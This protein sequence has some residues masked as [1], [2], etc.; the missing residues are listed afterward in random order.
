MRR[1]A[2]LLTTV[3][4]T[5]VGLASAAVADQTYSGASGQ[6]ITVSSL[7]GLP[8]ASTVHVTGTGFDETKGIYVAFCVDRGAGTLP[9]PCGGG[10]DMSGT[11]Q[12]SVWISSNP[13]SYG[14][15][16]AKPY[17]PGGSFA[18]D[19]H[20]TS[21]IKG[22]EETFDCREVRCAIVTRAD[23]TRSDDRSQDIRA[24]VSFAAAGPS[25]GD[26]LVIVAIIAVV[27]ALVLLLIV[28]RRRRR[29]IGAAVAA[30]AVVAS[31]AGCSGG[32]AS[33]SG[34]SRCTPQTASIGTNKVEP[35]AAPG[36]AALPVTLK[37]ADGA[38]VTVKDTSRILAVN[39][40]GSLA[41]IV[42]SLGL[43]DRVIGRDRSTDFEQASSLPYVTGSG[44][45]LSAEGILKLKP[46]VVLTDDT[47]GPPEVLKQLRRAGVPVVFFEH[48]ETLA[49]LPSRITSVAHALGVDTQGAALVKRLNTQLAS[50][51]AAALKQVT[52]TP[53]IAFLYL[54]GTAGVYLVG[55]QGAGSDDLIE[56]IGATDAGTVAGL[57]GFR[58]LTSEALIKSAPDVILVMTKSLASVGGIK[59]LL[60]L[61]G[62]AQTPAG[63]DH[64][65]VDMDDSVLLSFGTRTP[66]VLTALSTAVAATCATSAAQ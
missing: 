53:K 33:A 50:A 18:V 63:R 56:S 46:T 24:D 60:K 42:F 32:A 5:V 43:G 11:S 37:S 10:I 65:I 3:L 2:L 20:V 23:H 48:D 9:T 14:K 8:D 57:E 17:G 1:F 26:P 39:L 36:S 59:G 21:S 40:Y 62:V 4:A 44:H 19:V 6:S 27:L 28:S 29:T 61:P 51:K 41:D 22:P 25:L 12:G 31:A 64:R 34:P 45:D 55:G 66:Q 30:V 54:R 13:P 35:L 47:I 16:L 38:T 15:G 52:G 49:S 7:S 58:P